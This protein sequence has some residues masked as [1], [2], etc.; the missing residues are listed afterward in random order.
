VR[1]RGTSSDRASRIA[2]P[3]KSVIAHPG[4]DFRIHPRSEA[5]ALV[6][7]TLELIKGSWGRITPDTSATALWLRPSKAQGMTVDKTK[8]ST[9]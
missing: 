6:I 4:K 5:E 7:R 1:T 9:A 8:G 2:R 3:T